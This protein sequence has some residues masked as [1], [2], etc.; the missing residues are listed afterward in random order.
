MNTNESINKW[1]NFYSEGPKKGIGKVWPS[2][3]LVTLFKGSYFPWFQETCQGKKVLDIG[4]GSGNNLMF[5]ATLGMVLYG[6]E[7][8]EDICQQTSE[9]LL[10]MS[11]EADLKPGDNRNI[12]FSDNFFDY[13]ISWDVIHYEGREDRV[14]EAIAEYHRVLK[15]GGRFFLSTVAPDHTILRNSETLGGHRYEIG[16]EDDFRRGQ[17]FFSFDAPQ[18]IEFY[19]SKYFSNV[20][21]GRSNLNYFVETIDTFI[22]TGLKE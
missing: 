5:C 14:I 15:P 21:V 1:K 17:V 18:Y 16:R 6:V 22:A 3:T 19:F 4:F 2:E 12:P 10:E 8:H 13:L 7:V 20:L 9:R 11:Y